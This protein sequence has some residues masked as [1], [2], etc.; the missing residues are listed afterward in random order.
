MKP[1][2]W[3]VVSNHKLSSG[4]VINPENVAPAGGF[5]PDE[6]GSPRLR[7]EGKLCAASA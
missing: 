1:Y 4:P 3:F 2:P 5:S 6:T 7:A